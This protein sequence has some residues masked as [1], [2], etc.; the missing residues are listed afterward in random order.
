VKET[1][2]IASVAKFTARSASRWTCRSEKGAERGDGEV[3]ETVQKD[4]ADPPELHGEEEHPPDPAGQQ[5]GKIAPPA[6]MTVT[7]TREWVIP[8][9]PS[10]G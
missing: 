4:V 1:A 6:A 3:R 10:S 2:V 5:G 8:W 7:P 9:W